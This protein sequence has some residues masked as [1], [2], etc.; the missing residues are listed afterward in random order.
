M[1][2]GLITFSD[3]HF[4]WPVLEVESFCLILHLDNLG[5]EDISFESDSKC[6]DPTS[7]LAKITVNH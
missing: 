2:L 5:F 1:G 4:G 7:R 6:L 3:K